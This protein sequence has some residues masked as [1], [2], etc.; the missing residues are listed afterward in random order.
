MRDS[1]ADTKPSHEEKR[2]DLL[3][4]TALLLNPLAMGVNTVVGFTVAHWSNDTGRKSYSYLVC[5]VDLLICIVS[6]F[7]AVGLERKFRT[8][9]QDRPIDGRR[10]F[11]AR[12]SVLAAFLTALLLIAQTLATITLHTWD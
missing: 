8:A 2:K 10:L 1:L 4:W 11:M 9:E 3:L 5:A 7:L 12:L 6:F